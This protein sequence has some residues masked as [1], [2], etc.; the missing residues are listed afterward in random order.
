MIDIINAIISTG[1]GPSNDDP[2]DSSTSSFLNSSVILGACM[3]ALATRDIEEWSGPIDV[4]TWTTQAVSKWAWSSD[5]LGGLLALAQARFEYYLIILQ[6]KT[7]Y[8]ICVYCIHSPLHLT[9]VSLN[10]IYPSLSCSLLSPSRFLR[11]NTLRLLVSK[12]LIDKNHQD[13]GA[14]GVMEVLKRCLQ[15]EEVSL[16]L[17][18]VRERV[19]RIGR[20]GQVVGDV[21][22]AEVCARWLIG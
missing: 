10:V 9:P 17:Q 12:Q 16:D 22:G 11:L 15:G 19:L 18:G 2:G 4:G 20:V 6:K 3:H 7:D 13:P 14:D 8:I 21:R 5:V 1:P